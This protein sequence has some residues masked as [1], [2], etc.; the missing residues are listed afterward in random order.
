[1]ETVVE[2]CPSALLQLFVLLRRAIDKETPLIVHLADIVVVISVSFSKVFTSVCLGTYS[3]NPKQ[4]EQI[5]K[6][7]LGNLSDFFVSKV[8]LTLY[9]LA[10]E[11]F[12][13]TTVCGMLLSLKGWG[14]L[15][16]I[17]SFLLRYSI[18][19]FYFKAEDPTKETFK[20]LSRLL[21]SLESD[22]LWCANRRLTMSL[23]LVTTLEGG[24][25][26]LISLFL[27][28]SIYQSG[29]ALA[30]VVAWV[31]KILFYYLTYF[32]L[33][34]KKINKDEDRHPSISLSDR[35]DD[36]ASRRKN[37]FYPSPRRRAGDGK[38]PLKEKLL[39]PGQDDQPDP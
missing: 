35:S 5:K 23:H 14:V 12:R 7:Y 8:L 37:E 36:T 28:T 2:G 3:S 38:K 19:V 22:T 34:E 32:Q 33:T 30:S 11:I 39:S 13:L 17:P 20:V 4:L 10:S 21:M 26:V 29:L 16:F 6:F 25:F 24:M 15:F 18:V 31:F 1:L 27:S 9:H